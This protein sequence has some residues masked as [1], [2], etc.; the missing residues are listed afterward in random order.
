MDN[1][2]SQPATV[3]PPS[4]DAPVM[5][6]PTTGEEVAAAATDI[7]KTSLDG[8]VEVVPSMAADSA[9]ITEVP[10]PETPQAPVE[11][12]AMPESPM[13]S[14]D[15]PAEAPQSEM[16]APEAAPAPPTDDVSNSL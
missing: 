16:P 1:N 5:D 12:P 4:A 13:Q 2:Q 3:I 8:A 9:P 10:A 15:A 11:M 7:A 14:M 6:V